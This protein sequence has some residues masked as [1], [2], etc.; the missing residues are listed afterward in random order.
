MF[1]RII[2]PLDGSD[3]SESVLAWVAPLAEKLKAELI[4]MTIVETEPVPAP[5]VSLDRMDAPPESPEL[6]AERELRWGRSDRLVTAAT[7]Y[8]ESTAR[9]HVPASVHFKIHVV[10][11]NPEDQIVAQ[12]VATGADLIAMATHRSSPI[13]R[14]VLGSVADRVFHS[15]PVPLLLLRPGN[16]KA[17]VTSPQLIKNVIVPLDVSPISEKALGVGMDLAAAVNARLRLITVTAKLHVHGPMVGAPFGNVYSSGQLRAGGRDYL[18]QFVED[19]LNQGLEA[20]AVAVSG[21]PARAIIRVAHE[22][23]GSV[24]V[25]ASHGLSGFRRWVLGSVTDKVVRGAECP[26]LVLAVGESPTG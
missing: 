3:A 23:P 6:M 10:S 8:L 24:V 21:N 15:S 7:R 5:V 9:R 22:E 26:V 18:K 16:G 12:A 17:R 25:M 19:A 1:K 13:A 14:G 11:G 4:L 2:T 20:E